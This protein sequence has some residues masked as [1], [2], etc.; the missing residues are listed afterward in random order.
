MLNNDHLGSCPLLIGLIFHSRWPH[1]R[2]RIIVIIFTNGEA[3]VRYMYDLGDS[4]VS[5]KG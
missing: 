5:I 4:E 1:V 3:R 2:M